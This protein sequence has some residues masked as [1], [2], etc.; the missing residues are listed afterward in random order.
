[1]QA[2]WCVLPNREKKHCGEED[3]DVKLTVVL[4]NSE[5]EQVDGF[6]LGLYGEKQRRVC[7]SGDKVVYRFDRVDSV[8]CAEMW[9][10]VGESGMGRSIGMIG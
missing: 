1:M 10:T 2:C 6:P 7:F 9:E 4:M 8:Y 3:N 5:T